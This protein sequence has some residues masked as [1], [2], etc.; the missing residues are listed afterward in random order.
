MLKS[1]LVGLFT[2]LAIAVGSLVG[3]AAPASAATSDATLSNLYVSDYGNQTSSI[4]PGFSA[5]RTWYQVYTTRE[6]VTINAS[7]TDAAATIRYKWASNNDVVA[8]GSDKTLTLPTSFTVVT[9]EVTA[10]DGVTK[11][12]YTIQVNYRV[13]AQ[14][15]IL[16]VTPDSGSQIGGDRIAIRVKNPV[17]DFYEGNGLS[18]RTYF[19]FVRPNGDDRSSWNNYAVDYANDGTATFYIYVPN[20]NDW[21]LGKVDLRVMNDCQIWDESVNYWRNMQSQTTLKNA[22]EYKPV[23]FE[24]L[25]LDKANTTPTGRFTF[26]GQ[27]INSNADY[28][29]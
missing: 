16:S 1:R 26:T 4:K 6:N 19:Y 20:F 29:G 3:I 14:P 10:S 5:D 15:Q 2:V 23:V 21:Q 9:L 25:Q 8:S 28:W 22:F 27:G 12:N 18:C 24:A 17:V 7:S 13:L 11:K